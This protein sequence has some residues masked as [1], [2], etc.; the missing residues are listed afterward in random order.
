MPIAS[1]IVISKIMEKEGI[2]TL[3]RIA[4]E[5][6]IKE[7]ALKMLER[8]GELE[9]IPFAQLPIDVIHAYEAV[10]I[11]YAIEA[12]KG[13]KTAVVRDLRPE[14]VKDLGYKEAASGT[15]VYTWELNITAVGDNSY[16]LR[17][18]D[19]EALVIYGLEDLSPAMVITSITIRKGVTP[20]FYVSLGK[21]HVYER[22]AGLFT[23]PIIVEPNSDIT[24]VWRAI[25]TDVAP[26]IVLL[27]KK[28]EPEATLVS[29]DARLVERVRKALRLIYGIRRR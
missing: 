8:A 15:G 11:A 22:K 29:P 16:T 1:S 13:G 28:I 26:K 2:A 17:T 23:L 27:G 19:N 4:A 21:L 10:A 5:L 25:R 6:G 7:E 9:I 24:F 14:D 12:Y 18:G 20:Q 3:D